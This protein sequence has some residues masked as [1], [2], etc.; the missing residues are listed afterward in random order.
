MRLPRR[1]PH[2]IVKELFESCTWEEAGDPGGTAFK[3]A[4]YIFTESVAHVGI[5][6]TRSAFL[7]FGKPPNKALMKNIQREGLLR[8][9]HMMKPKPNVDQ[10]AEQIA[11]ENKKLPREE[12]SGPRG[13]IN[14]SSIAKH[15]R[16]L[17]KQRNKERQ[18]AAERREQ[19]KERLRT[20]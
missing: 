15:L 1:P 7:H 8:R 18:Q 14:V 9:Y 11:D 5:D 3:M 12:R 17:I 4:Y 10:L 6:R 2:E 13:S 16:R 20:F 19:L